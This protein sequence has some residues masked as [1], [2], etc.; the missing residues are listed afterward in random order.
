M[1]LFLLSCLVQAHAASA[2]TCDLEP[3]RE[4]VIARVIDGETV[5]LESGETVRLVGALAP[6][7]PSWWK[8]E[9]PW[10]A[11]ER[12]KKALEALVAGKA[13]RLA[14]QGRERDRHKRLLAHMFLAQGDEALWVQ[15]RLVSSGH[16]RAYSLPGSTACLRALQRLEE[17][18]RAGKLGLWRDPFYQVARASEPGKLM[19][20][21]YSYEIVEGRVASVASLRKWT[22]LNF[23]TDY[24]SDF[25]VAIAAGDRRGFAPDIET[26]ALEGRR[27]R[28]R[29]WIEFW[30]G[31]VIKA[32]H[33][34]QI[35]LL[36][37]RIEQPEDM[38]VSPA[39][40][41]GRQAQ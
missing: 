2:Q 40:P 20:R 31:P 14:T 26:D 23:G 9:M 27:I 24:R 6:S 34:E 38:P 28:V 30:N 35:E 16:A 19:K 41:G 22:F 18:A 29:G 4:G 25:T 11:A 32:T 3:S 36:A 7:A 13:V 17:E 37:E 21:R 5:A 39:R 12:G 33:P 10:R 1:A 15:G 8:G